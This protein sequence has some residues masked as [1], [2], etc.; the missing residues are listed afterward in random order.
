[1]LWDVFSLGE[2]SQ[3]AV[4]M[5]LDT[6]PYSSTGNSSYNIYLVLVFKHNE[7]KGNTYKNQF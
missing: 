7:Q 5:T 1:M 2:N 6:I 4:S 3:Y